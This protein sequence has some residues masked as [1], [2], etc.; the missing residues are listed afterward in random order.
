MKKGYSLVELMVA[1]TISSIMVGF[2]IS[3]YSKARDRQ[4]GRAAAEQVISILTQHQK[5]ANIG[6]MDC[7][8]IYLGQNI[9]ISNPGSVTATSQ[10]ST[11]SGTPEIVPIPNLTNI[12]STSIT[13]K[14]L[15]QGAVITDDPLN[16][17][18]T[19]TSGSTFRI[20]VTSTGTIEYK[21]IQ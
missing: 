14:P 5:K 10:C 7:T 4:V 9:S 18:F 6:D 1:V 12:T 17:D 2:G 19:T 21:G 8:G 16:I 20:E 3:A 11:S 13:F 15:T